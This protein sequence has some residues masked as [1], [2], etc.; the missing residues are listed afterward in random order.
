MYTYIPNWKTDKGKV[1]T[2]SIDRNLSSSRCGKN[3]QQS[4]HIKAMKNIDFE[5]WWCEK[6]INLQISK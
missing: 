6:V 3:V 1:K 2:N 5:Y 4:I